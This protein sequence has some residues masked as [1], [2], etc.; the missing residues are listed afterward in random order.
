MTAPTSITIRQTVLI[1]LSLLLLLLLFSFFYGSLWMEERH[2]IDQGRS[3]LEQTELSFL[4][5]LDEEAVKLS[6]ILSLLSANECLREHWLEENW[7]QLIICSK[8]LQQDLYD[9]LEIVE[10]NLIDPDQHMRLKGSTLENSDELVDNF[11]MTRVV[12]L[13]MAA[14]GLSLEPS[15]RLLFHSYIPWV[16]DEELTGYLEIGKEVDG[17]LEQLGETA[18]VGMVI[19]AEKEYLDPD[20]WS[21][22]SEEQD[23]EVEW[24]LY[25]AQIPV[26]NGLLEDEEALLLAMEDSSDWTSTGLRRLKVESRHYV[27][28]DFPLLDEGGQ[29]IGKVGVAIDHTKE[30]EN[31][32]Q[33]SSV[34]GVIT[35]LIGG[36]L[37]FFF[38]LYLGKTEGRLKK[39]MHSLHREIEVRRDLTDSLKKF[40]AAIENTGSAIFITDEQGRLSTLTLASPL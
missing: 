18:G 30:I 24:G 17:M 26:I 8:R 9:R 5:E 3:A 19:Y 36:M 20:A 23:E 7:R 16:V 21:H 35:V 12:N 32:K 6:N 2:Q 39:T 37:V 34:I 11:L 22:W 38:Y 4:R 15:G 25:E 1:P 31:S 10:L 27:L 28:G 13:Q 40:S 33:L 14:A 29:I